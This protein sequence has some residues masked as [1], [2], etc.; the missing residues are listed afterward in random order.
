MV[1]H[2]KST[3][4]A[5]VNEANTKVTQSISVAK[6]WLARGIS[7]N[8]EEV[9][10]GLTAAISYDATTMKAEATPV[11]AE[12]RQRRGVLAEK[13]RIAELERKAEQVLNEVQ[14]DLESRRIPIALSKLKEYVANPHATKR[15]FAEKLAVDIEDAASEPSALKKLLAMTDE[16]FQ[17]FRTSGELADKTSSTPTLTSIRRESLNRL[18][19]TAQTKREEVRIS[20]ERKKEFERQAAMKLELEQEERAKAEQ[21]RLAK[22]EAGAKA[23]REREA[24]KKA[25]AD[26]PQRLDID[27]AVQGIW[28]LYATSEDKGKTI[29]NYDGVAFARVSGTK[30]RTI[31][32]E[33]SNQTVEKVL[34]VKD[35]DGDPGNVVVFESGL[36]WA[37]TKKPR[38][39]YIIVQVM[40][41]RDDGMQEKIRFLVTASD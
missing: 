23:T 27:P 21:V 37:I 28:T 10:R 17:R 12:V 11:L 20:V 33:D 3:R 7:E 1:W 2:S 16:E 38:Q 40:E 13:A 34:I 22:V 4:D 41:L 24:A 14:K 15:P 29:K 5:E 9:E 35:E 30:V 18:L 6:D 39:K 8:G 32:G 25:A 26:V 31:F 19:A 36:I